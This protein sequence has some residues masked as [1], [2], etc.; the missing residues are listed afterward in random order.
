MPGRSIPWRPACWSIG[1]GRATRLLR[2]L[3]DLPKT[4]EGTMRLGE[5]T[6]TLD[7][8]GEVTRRASRR[9]SRTLR[10]PAPWRRSWGTRMQTPP[11][12]TAVKVGGR[13]LYEAARE[14][15][16][17]EAAPRPVHVDV[18]ESDRTQRRR[19]RLPRGLRRRDVRS[20]AGGRRGGCARVRRAPHPSA[21]HRH[22]FVLGG[23]TPSRPTNPGHRCPSRRRW[24]IC[25]G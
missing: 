6:T 4:Y 25:P 1:V 24:R 18:F 19:R 8:E 14:G 5:E 23:A 12:Y 16:A 9:R 11:A 13:K 20:R 17:L 15:E 10:S 2:F 3:G 22:R 7:A 21:A